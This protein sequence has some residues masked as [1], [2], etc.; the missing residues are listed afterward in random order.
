[1]SLTRSNIFVDTGG[2]Y[3]LIADADR[4]HRAAVEYYQAA[5]GGGALLLTSDYVLDETLT[6]LRYDFGHQVAITFWRLVS[7]AQ[8]KGLLQVLH[9]DEE[10]WS[11]NGD[12]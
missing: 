2:W 9:V 6:R 1:M 3:A 4:Y 11:S 7:Q 5:V 8:D 10:V 12:F